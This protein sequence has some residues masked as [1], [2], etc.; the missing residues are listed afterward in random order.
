MIIVILPNNEKTT[1]KHY[2]AWLERKNYPLTLR[3]PLT[4]LVMNLKKL[5]I[6]GIAN[7]AIKIIGSQ[8][9]RVDTKLEAWVSRPV[10]NPSG[11]TIHHVG[12]L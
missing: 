4:Y 8:F 9:H 6:T 5:T 3:F 1:K 2:P 7:V 12:I 11:T 10:W